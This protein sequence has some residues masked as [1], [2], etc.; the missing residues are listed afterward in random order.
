M[1]KTAFSCQ[2]YTPSAPTIHPSVELTISTHDNQAPVGL[3]TLLQLVPSQW[4]MIPSEPTA[5]PSVEL[6]ISMD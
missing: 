1:G 2:R 4:I 6:T 5:H 3:A